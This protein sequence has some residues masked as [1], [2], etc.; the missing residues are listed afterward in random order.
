MTWFWKRNKWQACWRNR[1]LALPKSEQNQEVR[2][3]RRWWIGHTLKKYGNS[4][5]RKSFYWNHRAKETQG[6][7]K[8]KRIW[9]ENGRQIKLYGEDMK[10]MVR[11]SGSW[12]RTSVLMGDE[13]VEGE[14]WGGGEEEEEWNTVP[15]LCVG[16]GGWVGLCFF[17]H[18]HLFVSCVGG[19]STACTQRILTT[20]GW[21]N[22]H[23]IL[24]SVDKYGNHCTAIKVCD[25]DF[26][27]YRS[28]PCC[29]I[30]PRWL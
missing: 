12:L 11:C 6:G 1:D 16:V 15:E 24:G 4:L 27:R 3:R 28:S 2:K 22:C 23:F 21:N 25:M 19:R 30:S 5:T 17:V 8:Q 14:G 7:L 20:S 9:E 13:K 26:L 18:D 29:N 10:R